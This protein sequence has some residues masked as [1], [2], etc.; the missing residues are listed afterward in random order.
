[1]AVN[2]WIT[3]AVLTVCCLLTMIIATS[4]SLSKEYR[5]PG[6]IQ[7]QTY[8][9]TVEKA[10]NIRDSLIEI[11]YNP[12]IGGHFYYELPNNDNLGQTTFMVSTVTEN[13]P[14]YWWKDIEVQ[15]EG[16][17]LEKEDI[18]GH[19]HVCVIG[20]YAMRSIFGEEANSEDVLGN[21]L[22]I[23]DA[24][25]EIVGIIGYGGELGKYPVDSIFIPLTTAIDMGE[26]AIDYIDIWID[27]GRDLQAE[28]KRVY[29][30]LIDRGYDVSVIFICE[31][32]AGSY[33]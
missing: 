30:Y 29:N 12:I 10:M 1:M 11:G 21:K 9:Y 17:N 14:Q 20:N 22:Q 25:Y 31:E 19:E 23:G 27:D 26:D 2:R 32:A 16:R 7:I 15:I 3:S 5:L 4:C 24:S 28:A 8:P 18:D 13:Y 6:Y 33:P